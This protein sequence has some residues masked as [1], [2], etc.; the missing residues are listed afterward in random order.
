M[1]NITF[2]VLM[3]KSLMAGPH[4]PSKYRSSLQYFWESPEGLSHVPVRGPLDSSPIM[5]LCSTKGVGLSAAASLSGLR[6]ECYSRI[7][8]PHDP[9]YA[10][11]MR[12]PNKHGTAHCPHYIGF[13]TCSMHK[14]EIVPPSIIE[15][16]GK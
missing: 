2:I 12:P 14:L 8:F 4:S 3:R 11:H 1:C 5:P 15:T 9:S 13:M 10:K 7:P 6:R 16:E